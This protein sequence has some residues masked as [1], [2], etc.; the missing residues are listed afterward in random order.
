M[1][2]SPRTPTAADETASARTPTAADETAPA[3]RAVTAVDLAKSFGDLQAVSGV[4]ISIARGQTVALLGPNG[5]GKTTT[6]SLLLG[7]LPPD[8]GA[9][10]LLGRAPEQAVRA[11]LVG[12]MLQDGGLMPGVRVGELLAMLARLYPSPLTVTE[13][14]AVA[15]VEH[16][17]DRR[18]ERL[19]AGQTQRLRVAAALIAG[20]ELLVLDEPTTAM[21]V[22]ARHRFWLAMRDEADRGRTILFSTHYLEEADAYADRVVVVGDG[23]VIAD[24]TP[25]DI[26]GSLGLRVLRCRLEHPDPRRLGR[27]PGVETVDAHHGRVELRTRDS[28]ATLRALLARWDDAADIEIAGVGLEEAFLALT[29]DRTERRAS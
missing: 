28:D 4:S 26:K 10:R 22:E 7:L 21:D 20:P 18:V 15:Q 24:G 3:A 5:A 25:A 1:P 12:A 11:G 8:R 19:S 27:L 29:A 13:T 2:R 6:I 23:R 17:L 14:A 16:L 9:V